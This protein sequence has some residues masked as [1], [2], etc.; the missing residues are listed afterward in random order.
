[1]HVTTFDNPFTSV[2]YK[3]G[4][5]KSFDP[6]LAEAMLFAKF[7]PVMRGAC[8]HAFDRAVHVR[9]SLRL[10]YPNQ[11][12]YTTAMG[13]I[14]FP[15]QYCPLWW[16]LD[17]NVDPLCS[18]IGQWLPEKEYH[19]DHR[20]KSWR[21]LDEITLH[22]SDTEASCREFLK[23]YGG[24]PGK[25]IIYG[26]ANGWRRT[27]AQAGLTDYRIVEK[28][29]RP[30]FG[31]RL[32]F[33]IRP[34]NPAQRDRVNAVNARLETYDGKSHFVISGQ[35]CPKTIQDIETVTWIAGS[36]L[37]D[38]SKIA[39]VTI[40]STHFTDALGYAIERECPILE[41]RYTAA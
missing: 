17:F 4:L 12:V 36:H 21:V 1:M 37:I 33:R 24:W 3:E 27:T 38:K 6:K 13:K 29:L 10:I 23:R 19:T 16:S 7:V 14:Q 41:R 2:E 34:M 26:D 8:Y 15:P 31:T 11:P 9:D 20:A 32:E 30:V 25:V 40:S 28:M 39:K 22:N 5:L 18:V 35:K